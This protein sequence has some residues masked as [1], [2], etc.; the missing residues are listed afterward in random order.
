MQDILTNQFKQFFYQL[1]S[2][3]SRRTHSHQ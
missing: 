3:C 2:N 1:Y